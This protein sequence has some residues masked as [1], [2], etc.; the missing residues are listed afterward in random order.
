MDTI[1]NIFQ[2]ISGGRARKA[3]FI[4]PKSKTFHVINLSFLLKIMLRT[5][6]EARVKYFRRSM[7]KSLLNTYNKLVAENKPIPTFAHEQIPAILK[8]LGEKEFITDEYLQEM[9]TKVAH[10]LDKFR[11]SYFDRNDWDTLR[12]VTYI[13]PDI[14]TMIREDNITPEILTKL[15]GE[16]HTSIRAVER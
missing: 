9:S 1:S 15:R 11:L 10:K 5:T 14:M 12:V 7:L 8:D 2:I 16:S 4:F 6:A 3:H 13:E